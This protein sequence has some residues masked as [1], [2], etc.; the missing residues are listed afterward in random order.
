MQVR[1]TINANSM[2]QHLIKL[3]A[4][5]DALVTRSPT[6]ACITITPKHDHR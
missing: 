6:P 5:K 2:V 3:L 1:S 4:H